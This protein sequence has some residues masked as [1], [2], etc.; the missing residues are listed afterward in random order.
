MTSTPSIPGASLRELREPPPPRRT[1]TGVNLPWRKPLANEDLTHARVSPHQLSIF[2][3]QVV[4]M[5]DSGMQL[6]NALHAYGQGDPTS[7]GAVSLA[8]SRD[9]AS[10]RSLVAAMSRYPRVFSPVYLGLVRAGETT[11]QLPILL[12]KLSELLERQARFQSHLGTALTYPVFLVAV[13][14]FCG[15]LFLLFILPALEPLFQSLAVELPLPTRILMLLGRVVRHPVTWIGLPLAIGSL[16]LLGPG[17]LRAHP[18]WSERLER[19]PLELPKLGPVIQKL[20]GARLLFTLAILLEAGITLNRALEVCVG[21]TGNP[22][23][24]RKVRGVRVSLQDGDTLVRALEANGLFSRGV[25][26]VIAVGEEVSSLTALMRFCARV[27]E[28]D[29]NYSLTSFLALLEPVLLAVLGI[30]SGFLVLAAVL[31]IAGII[32]AL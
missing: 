19:L 22:T 14:I 18:E 16:W 17:L 2:T 13:G 9:L 25:R 28:E 7:L 23:M 5:L 11:G 20:M 32:E 24:A 8:M 3:H 4:A 21:V 27:Y 29:A 1:C 15:G 10:G 26:N 6:A 31:P 12:R 30:G